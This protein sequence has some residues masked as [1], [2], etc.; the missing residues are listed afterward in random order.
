MPFRFRPGGWE[1]P[2]TCLDEIRA[3]ECTWRQTQSEPFRTKARG[4]CQTGAP[5]TCICPAATLLPR[6]KQAM[7]PIQGPNQPPTMAVPPTDEGEADEV[8]YCGRSMRIT[9]ARAVEFKCVRI[10]PHDCLRSALPGFQRRGF[11][12][13]GT[14]EARGR[15]AN[16]VT[17][18]ESYWIAFAFTWRFG[19]L[20]VRRPRDFTAGGCAAA[21]D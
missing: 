14:I 4:L 19:S 10:N 21:S 5:R 18:V 11:D 13:G 3:L 2:C 6:C 15:F 12:V 1:D 16:S 20:H 9:A 7:C 17:S 8:R